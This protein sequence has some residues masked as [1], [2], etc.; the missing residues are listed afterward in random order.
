MPSTSDTAGEADGP[1]R[2]GA[3]ASPDFF[4]RQSP[5]QCFMRR[6]CAGLRVG[7]ITLFNAIGH[8]QQLVKMEHRILATWIEA[9]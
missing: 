8:S 3:I 7:R 5:P 1:S 6:S 9:S 4:G 2:N